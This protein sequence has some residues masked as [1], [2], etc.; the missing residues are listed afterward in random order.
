MPAWSSNNPKIIAIFVQNES[1]SCRSPSRIWKK[2]DSACQCLTLEQKWVRFG[3]LIC[4]QEF[5]C[6]C[7]ILRCLNIGLQSSPK[8]ETSSAA[9]SEAE[10]LCRDQ[11][12]S[13]NREM[14]SH[15]LRVTGH[16]TQQVCLHRKEPFPQ[17][18]N[19]WKVFEAGIQ[20]HVFFLSGP[21]FFTLS[22]KEI[23]KQKA[24]LGPCC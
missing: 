10:C 11:L 21:T 15:L 17:I 22:M 9:L 23:S 19:V 20:N 6:T 16:I 5:R 12:N 24:C 14:K 8:W 3:S 2:I 1:W 7:P 13:L 18:E 4:L